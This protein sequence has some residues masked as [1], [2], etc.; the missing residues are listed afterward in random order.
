MEYRSVV[1]YLALILIV[2][3]LA[4]FYVRFKGIGEMNEKVRG[5]TISKP[6]KLAP[7]I[8]LLIVSIIVAVLT[9]PS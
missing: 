8:I 5:V 2:G 6:P 3:S 7:P 1:F 9:F 4:E